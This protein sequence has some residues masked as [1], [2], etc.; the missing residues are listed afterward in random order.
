MVRNGK[1]MFL[2]MSALTGMLAV[3]SSLAG[4]QSDTTSTSGDTTGSGGEGGSN[5]TSSTG[6]NVGGGSSTSTASSMTTTTTTGG[7][8]SSTS[9]G[10]QMG[11]PT[12]VV[13]ITTGKV[14]PGI[15][16]QL[17][18]VVAMSRKFLVSQSK[19]SGSCLWGVFISDKVAET[20]PSTGTIALAYGMNAAIPPGGTDAVCPTG[21]DAFPN[22]TKLGDVLDISGQSDAYIPKTCGQKPGESNVAEYQVSK[23]S[24]AVK[25]GTT[26][27]P[28]PHV[29]TDAEALKLAD[30]TDKAFHDLWG[31]V[32]VRVA[33][34]SPVLFTPAGGGTGTVVGPYG[35]IK[36]AGSNVEVVDKV[37]YAKGAVDTCQQAPK[38]ADATVKFTSVDG[39]SYLNYCTW[40]LAPNDRCA[41]FAP[42]SDDCAGASCP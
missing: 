12:T 13:E 24:S 32:K 3:W 20:A 42:K 38:Y 1:M 28:T 17:K 21:T 16:V 26:T 29:L 2:G 7:T 39:F 18:G 40:S 19:S 31:G 41:D 25:T 33:N 22:D 6:V 37:Y 9:S 23:V 34:V 5:V 36:L 8:T 10:G 4:C 11:L 30:Q 27:A 15:D 35:V 14:G